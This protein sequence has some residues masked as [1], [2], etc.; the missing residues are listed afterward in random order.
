MPGRAASSIEELRAIVAAVEA[1]DAE[2]AAA[3]CTYHVEQAGQVGLKALAEF[4]VDD[5]TA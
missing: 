4:E 3:A 5:G 1:N 2:A